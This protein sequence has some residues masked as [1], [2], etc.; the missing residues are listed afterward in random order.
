MADD[1]ELKEA[2]QQ[3]QDEL[4]NQAKPDPSKGADQQS[5]RPAGSWRT[6]YSKDARR[7]IYWEFWFLIAVFVVECV[8]LPWVA[9]WNARAYLGGPSL[10][11]YSLA[12]LGGLLGGWMFT[13]RWLINAVVAWRWDEDRHLW[14]CLNPFI[15]ASLALSVA[16]NRSLV[17]TCAVSAGSCAA[18]LAVGK[19]CNPALVVCGFHSFMV[20][21]FG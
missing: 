3:T 5:G 16:E 8:L 7:G 13:V 11:L 2:E 19:L 20:M 17:S 12:T 9:C 15:A 10:R 6:R 21:Q 1:V 4:A 18:M 14:R